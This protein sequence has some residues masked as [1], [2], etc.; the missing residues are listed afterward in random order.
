[1][2]HPR[3]TLSLI[4]A[5]IT[6][7]GLAAVT[8]AFTTPAAAASLVQVTN[9]GSN[10]GNMQMHVYVPDA[11]PAKPGIVVAMHGCGGS[12]PGF[13]SSSEFAS[14]ANRYGFIVIYPTA[15]QHAGF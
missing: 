2:R 9:F 3:R 14:L 11:R 5:G 4:T 8:P 12:G 15:T 6:T 7:L 13:F 10:P 1:M